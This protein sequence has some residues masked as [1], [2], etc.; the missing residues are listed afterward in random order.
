[1]IK[2]FRSIAQNC[3]PR[4]IRAGFSRFGEGWDAKEKTYQD[5][6]PRRCAEKE[7]EKMNTKTKLMLGLSALTAGTLAAGATGTFA[8]FTTNKSAKATYSKITASSSTNNLKIEIGGVSETGLTAQKNWSTDENGITTYTDAKLEATKSGTTDVSSADG[9]TFKKPNWASASGNSQKVNETTPFTKTVA[10][11]D[12]TMFYVK[13]ENTG[14]TEANIFLDSKTSIT[15]TTSTKNED[16]ALARWTRLA[17]IDAGTTKPEIASDGTLPTGTLKWLY[18]NA[19]QLGDDISK[20]VKDKKDDYSLELADVTSDTHVTAFGSISED[21]QSGTGY[22]ATIDKSAAK[23]YLFSVWMEGTEND[24][25]DAAVGGSIDITLS[26]VA[27]K[28]T[29]N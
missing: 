17:V 19:A 21:A 3:R 14:S 13:V 4:T 11:T 16:V 7:K 18:E 6:H 1:M 23:Y 29:S 2:V 22:L 28:K 20:Y 27:T 26:F 15:A 9:L 12:F 8:W 10:G 24:A 5:A 25:Q